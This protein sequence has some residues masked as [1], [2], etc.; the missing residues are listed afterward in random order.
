M[1]PQK[2]IYR[3]KE[4]IHYDYLMSLREDLIKDFFNAHPE[5]SNLDDWGGDHYSKDGWK[6]SI[7]QYRNWNDK[8]DKAEMRDEMYKAQLDAAKEKYPTVYEKI[9]QKWG[10]DCIVCGYAALMP[11]AVMQRH[12]GDEN[13]QAKNIRIHIPLI[14]PDG[15]I[16]M[17]IYGEQIDWSDLFAFDN[18]KVHS[19]WNFTD[20]PRLILMVDLK[21]NVCE[22]PDGEP[23]TKESEDTAPP[24]PKLYGDKIGI[25]EYIPYAGQAKE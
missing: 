18:Q 22:L 7:I 14:V 19:V 10:D 16:G 17:E 20:K 25:P 12:T 23:W 8:E 5:Y 11:G 21:R 15:D 13:R 2:N 24:F 6:I 4:I 3:S 1:L 9:L